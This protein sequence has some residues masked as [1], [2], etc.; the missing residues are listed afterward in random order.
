MKFLSTKN[1]KLK[2]N[3][4]AFTLVE[5]MVAVA[6]FSVVM[7]VSVGSLLS[8][9][10]AS[11]R[12]Q[13]IQSVM[14][15]LNVA[16]DGMVRSMRMGRN[17]EIENQYTLRF[18]PFGKPTEK[19]TYY[20]REETPAGSPEPRGRLYKR[21][22]VEGIGMV[23]VPLTA[24]EVDID[25]VQFYVTGTIPNDNLQPR[26]MMIVRGKAGYETPKTTTYFNI[27][28]SA[29]QRLLDL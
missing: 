12:A 2:T 6:L 29:T 23:D 22:T 21:Y 19:W 28:A 20:F 16:L 1:H 18:T 25:S 11:K 5:M 15:N 26:T 13:G 24:Q 7:L 10:D 3:E 8:L 9:I 4:S 17:Y 27:Q 14:N